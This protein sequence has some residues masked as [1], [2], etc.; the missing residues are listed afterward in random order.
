[1]EAQ[2]RERCA[3]QI[4]PWQGLRLTNGAK[5]RLQL[6]SYPRDELSRRLFERNRRAL[7]TSDFLVG[8]QVGLR[9]RRFPSLHFNLW[10]NYS[11]LELARP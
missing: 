8:E 11:L 3:R 5:R 2:L 7:Y 10:Y 4:Q 6:V 1:M 9:H